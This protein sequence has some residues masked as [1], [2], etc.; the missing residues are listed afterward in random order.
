M[1]I[2][3]PNTTRIQ[4]I[5][6]GENIGIKIDNKTN[7][8]LAENLDVSSNP[9]GII[10]I[11]IKNEQEGLEDVVLVQA[12]TQSF[13]DYDDK[14]IKNVVDSIK[15][16]ITKVPVLSL[17][18]DEIAAIKNATPPATGANYFM[19][20]ANAIASFV[21][22][23]PNGD[24]GSTN[25]QDAIVEV[26]DDTDT[27]L[28][29][30]Q[31]TS[32]KS[33]P[34]G[35]AS[36]D[37]S[38]QVPA[39][40][41]PNDVTD[42]STHS[43]TE[44][45]DV[46]NAGS[47]EI[48]T[49]AERLNLN[50]SN[51][52]AALD[53]APNAITG[54]NPVADKQYVDG[55]IDGTLKTPESYDP[56]GSGN[57]PTTYGG[58]PVEKGDSFRILTADTLG[59]GTIVNPED[60]LIAD[61]DTPGQTDANWQVVESNRDQ[62]TETVKG[63]AAISTV[64]EVNTGTDDTKFI[65][66]SKLSNSQLQTDVTANNAKV[67]ADGSI[68]THSDV[69]TTNEA[70]VTGQ[71][72][73]RWNGSEWESWRPFSAKVSSANYSRPGQTTEGLINQTT[74]LEEY[75]RLTFTPRDDDNYLLSGYWERSLNDGSQ[76][77]IVVAEIREVVGDVLVATLSNVQVEPKDVGGGGLVLNTIS[78]GVIGGNVNSGTNQRETDSFCDN[79][80]LT[81]G[82]QYYLRIQWSGS[83]VNIEATLYKANLFVT[84]NTITT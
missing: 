57:F 55:L 63:V 33:Q 49:E 28:A 67:S 43:V 5:D 39:G 36:L 68:D 82:T 77:I 19:T 25:V 23:T 30:K 10:T 52:K 64:A 2:V 6:S 74:T 66:P 22:F 40:E 20:I 27:K 34:N 41:L 70:K 79:V 83:N 15:C 62:A 73:L 48:I 14:S 78:G 84:Q 72:L 37:G 17:T 29:S 12:Y 51:Q 71:S 59:S 18:L 7:Y 42:L 61:I 60:L 35:Y 69:D 9:Q 38:G 26:R 11:F 45:N 75:L 54:A 4:L 76:D 8:Y 81:G 13:I 3:Y 56:A 46:T 80:D 16:L 44:L 24:I 65:T 53:N 1:A 47:G 58:N 32:E 31:N 21:S 50:T